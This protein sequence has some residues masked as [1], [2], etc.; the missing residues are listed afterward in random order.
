MRRSLLAVAL[1]AAALAAPASA[2]A[3]S[4]SISDLRV[5]GGNLVGTVAVEGKGC[6][7]RS[8]VPCGWFG[9]VQAMP[10]AAPCDPGSGQPGWTGEAWMDSRTET[11]TLVVVLDDAA[12]VRLCVFVYRPEAPDR[13]VFETVFDPPDEL[14]LPA[15]PAA[16][17]PPP[18]ACGVWARLTLQREREHRDARTAYRRLR[19]PARLRTMRIALEKLETARSRVLQLC[20]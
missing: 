5:E 18:D 15:S 9:F 2:L 4:G 20:S 8:L 17:S 11:G 12:P 7:K 10:V 3:D 19:S 16:A 6:P 14:V 13:L 1:G